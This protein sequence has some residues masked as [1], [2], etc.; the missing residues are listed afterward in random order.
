MTDHDSTAGT[1]GPVAEQETVRAIVAYRPALAEFTGRIEG[2]ALMREAQAATGLS[3][4]GGRRWD[5]ERFRHDFTLLCDAIEATAQVSHP[6]RSRSH[7]R[8]HTMLVSRL[9]YIAAREATRDVDA[10]RIVAP[11]VGSGMPRAGTTFLHGLI[12]QDPAN[13]VARAYE[14]AMPVPLAG[15]E[16]DARRELYHRILDFQGTIDPAVTSIHPFGADLPEECIFL[17]EGDCG[18]LY[19]VYWNVPDFAAATADKRASAFDWQLGVMQYFQAME[20]GGRWALKA[21][22]HMFVWDEMRMA[23]PDALIYVNHRDPARVV[24]SIT[25]LFMALR[26]LFSDTASDPVE[27]G[28]G[29]LAAWSHAMNAYVDW[30]SGP[31]KD[32]NVIDIHFSDLTARPVETV[33]ELYD[34]FAIP[35]TAQFRERLLRHLDADHHGKGPKRQYTLAE[36]GMDEAAIETHFARYIDHFGIQREKRT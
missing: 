8:L 5:E 24:P 21:P 19:T 3:D 32:A 1:T 2:E 17:Q 15:P 26:G 22:G 29:Q 9:R 28:A 20:P 36:F 16:G 7:C 23:F 18:S 35:F 12:A 31:G 33:E 27:V 10:Q 30:R 11:L 4:W 13:R 25:S 34:R 14:A 6:G